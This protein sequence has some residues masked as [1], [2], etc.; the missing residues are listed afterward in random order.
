MA[1]EQIFKLSELE[2]P[3]EGWYTRAREGP[4]WANVWAYMEEMKAGAVFPP[5]LVGSFEGR[6]IVVDGYHR[7]KATR[8][9]KE[10][11]IKG[12]LKKYASKA[13]LL[14]DAVE[15]NNHHGVRYTPQDKAHIARL[16]AEV[17][18]TDVAISGLIGV[19]VEKLVNFTV[20]SIG[21][22]KTL[23]AP[24]NRLV[25]EGKITRGEAEEV[26]ASRLST[27]TL[28]DVLVQLVGYLEFGVYPWGDEK[29]DGYARRIVELMKPHIQG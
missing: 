11:F 9:L 7:V 28:D 16:L 2:T 12:V 6:L 26:E 27:M 8:N 3:L 4:W 24:L 21:N 14:R 18:L 1:K 5:I 23:K 29:Y 10:E 19:R 13:D 15:A 20:R 25:L 22:G 17:G